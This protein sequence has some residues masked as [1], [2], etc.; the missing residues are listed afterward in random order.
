MEMEWLKLTAARLIQTLSLV[1]MLMTT[2]KTDYNGDCR[3]QRLERFLTDEILR[4]CGIFPLTYSTGMS[5]LI[6]A[7]IGEDF[8]VYKKIVRRWIYYYIWT[9]KIL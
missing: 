7:A 4:I 8:L 1:T 2:Q 9:R 5:S 6:F 3:N